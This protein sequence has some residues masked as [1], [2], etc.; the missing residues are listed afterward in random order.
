MVSLS[1]PKPAAAVVEGMRPINLRTDLAQLADLIEIVFADSMDSNGRATLREMRYLS[2][3]GVGLP[4]LSRLNEL[5]LD[6]SMGYVWVD[7]DRL[8]GNVS[9]YPTNWPADLG[10]AWIIA[11]VGVHPDYQRRGIARQL[12]RASMEMIRQRSSKT[13]RNSV[14]ILQVDIDNHPARHLY[15]TLGFVEE[16]A[17]T[18]WRR[19]SAARRP[20]SPPQPARVFITRRRRSQWGDEFALAQ[21]LR[22]HDLGGLGWLKPLHRTQFRKSLWGNL[23]DALNLRTTE[24]LII[25][26]EADDSIAASLWIENMLGGRATLSMM[27]D[28]AYQGVYDDLL[29]GTVVRR[30]GH[31]PMSIEHPEDETTSSRIL[32]KYHFTRQRTVMHMRWDVR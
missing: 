25:Q 3:L 24:R 17:W 16:R 12:M 27:V 9:V 6:V 22:P 5:A 14:A 20:E 30:L 7:N 8:V 32:E 15:R 19:S 31:M 13:Y 2:K 29:L 28:P 4:L 1:R 11:N 26:S 10:S 23:I 18:T 21:R